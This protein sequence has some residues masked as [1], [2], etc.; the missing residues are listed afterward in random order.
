MDEVH[1]GSPTLWTSR[2]SDL[3]LKILEVI[4][5]GVVD[6]VPP[7]SL[8]NGKSFLTSGLRDFDKSTLLC[9]SNVLTF[10]HLFMDPTTVDSRCLVQWIVSVLIL[11]ASSGHWTLIY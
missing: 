8:D 9:S 11:C 6:R 5:Y 2:I 4:F 3:K 10:M 7:V 1:S